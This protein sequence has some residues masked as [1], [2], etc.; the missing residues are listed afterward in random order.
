MLNLDELKF[1][2]YRLQSHLYETKSDNVETL[3]W[4]IRN[5]KNDS[6][7]GFATHRRNLIA[8]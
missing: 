8:S 4:D 3:K 7:L 5:L 2:I 6:I 1:D